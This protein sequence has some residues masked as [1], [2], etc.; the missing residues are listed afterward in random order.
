MKRNKNLVLILLI[1]LLVNNI[2][3]SQINIVSGFES[4]IYNQ[5]AKD[6]KNNTEVPINIYSTKGS[7]DNFNRLISDSIQIAFMQYDVLLFKEL[8]NHKIKEYIR[9][10]LPL[11]NEEIHLI[12]KNNKKINSLADLN[13]K[14]VAVGSK[15]AGS[16]ITTDFIKLKTE[17]DWK[18]YEIPFED[19]FVALLSDSI[20][21]FFFVGAAPANALKSL[22]KGVKNIIKLVPIVD[23][24]LDD[25]YIKKTIKSGTYSW[26]SYEIKTYCVP[27]LL[28]L[29][30]KN[31]SKTKENKI[32]LLYNDLKNNLKGIRQNKLSHPK[33]KQVDF[34]DRKHIDWPVY[35]K[36]YVSVRLV[37]N[38]LAYFA[39]ILSF[40]QIYFMINKLWSRKHEKNVA[41]SIS[42]SAMFISILINGSFVFN[43]FIAGGIPQFA[44]NIMWITG[45]II[46]AFIGVGYWVAGGRKKG[47]WLL[48]KQA[49][50]LERK[51]AG[52]LAKAFFSP[53]GAETI[54]EI[55]GQV[56]M[57]DGDLD[58]REMNFIQPFADAW[59]ITIDWSYIKENFGPKSGV[60]FH[61]LRCSMTKYLETSPPETQVSQLGDILNMLVNADAQVTKEEELMMD[62]L[63]G[64][65]SGYLSGESEV[66]IFKVAVVPQNTSQETAIS[67]IIKDLH[68]TE[69]AGGYAYLSE[70]FY[71]E[72]Y[73]EVVCEKYRA[74][75]IFTV[76]IKPE[77]INDSHEIISKKIKDSK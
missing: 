35:K 52:D 11:Y 10:F 46:M 53:S 45:S 25:I 26:V 68:K 23:K 47:I 55:L 12:A 50:K 73:A 32:E 27:S 41:E 1:F 4:E 48:L 19:A 63:T 54:I 8:E 20:D 31:I 44:A 60:G 33:W 61:D 62:E 59:D 21:A 70:A 2:S 34:S 5:F 22:S 15:D 66:P 75:N 43:N 38:L 72:K 57:I 37:S 18:D 71:S 40:F 3:F 39:A 65:I 16:H 56:A 42:I 6:I 74:L 58:E 28:V 64:I 76:V 69:I 29:N 13:G 49:L 51:E 7:V 36:E 24:R 14:R 9:V 17:I 67:T 30:T 77:H